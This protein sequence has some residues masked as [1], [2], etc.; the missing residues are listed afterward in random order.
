MSWKYFMAL[1][2]NTQKLGNVTVGFFV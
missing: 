2:L 1:K